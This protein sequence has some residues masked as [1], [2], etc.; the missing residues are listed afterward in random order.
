M[1]E[2]E[3]DEEGKAPTIAPMPQSESDQGCESATPATEGILVELDTE[4]WLIDLDTKVL[5]PTLYYLLVFIIGVSI[6]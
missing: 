6:Q 2:Q 4:D 5:P 1:S 3:L